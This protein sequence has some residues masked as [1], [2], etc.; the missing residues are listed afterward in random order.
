MGQRTVYVKRVVPETE[1]LTTSA[2]ESDSYW[3]LFQ[4]EIGWCGLQGREETVERFLMGLPARNDLLRVIRAETHRDGQSSAKS[5]LESNW[6]PK[7]QERLQDY[8]QGAHVEFQDVKLKLTKMTPF[9][10]RVVQALQQIGYGRQITYGE[11]A[12]RA[13]SPRAARA[14]GTVMSSNRIP[15]LI[16]CHRV[17]ASGG[18]LGGFSAPQGTSLKEHLLLLESRAEF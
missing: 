10:S 13:S 4:T 12:E 11:L 6:Y 2:A 17:I 7:L 14:V 9:Q 16:P 18:K 8:F 1:H 3:S 15:I 5:V